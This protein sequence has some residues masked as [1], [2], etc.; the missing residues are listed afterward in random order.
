MTTLKNVP[1]IIAAVLIAGS[2]SAMAVQ[3][4]P[5]APPTPSSNANDPGTWRSSTDWAW[6]LPCDQW[7]QNADGSWTIPGTVPGTQ[8]TNITVGGSSSKEGRI[9]QQRC[10]GK[11][12]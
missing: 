3:A 12:K 11:G 4:T 8:I 9:L 1:C 2:V 7:R 5:S 6:Y 10:G